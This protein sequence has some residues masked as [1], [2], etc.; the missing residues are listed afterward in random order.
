[1]LT[2]AWMATY[3]S[4]SKLYSKHNMSGTAPRLLAV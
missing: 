4:P 3:G 1:M 2:N